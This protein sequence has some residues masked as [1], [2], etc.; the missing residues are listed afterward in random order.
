M[1]IRSYLRHFTVLPYLS[2]L[3]LHAQSDHRQPAD[4]TLVEWLV[5]FTVAAHWTIYLTMQ[6]FQLDR[7]VTEP[8]MGEQGLSGISLPGSQ[9]LKASRCSC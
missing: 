9:T 6:L 2:M 5:R 7:D 4:L 1:S 3:Q 8:A